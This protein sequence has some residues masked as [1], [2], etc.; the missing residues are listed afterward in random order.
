MHS[1]FVSV[2]MALRT[3]S[4]SDLTVSTTVAYLA[5]RTRL[6]RRLVFR[7]W[8]RWGGW[9]KPRWC[10]PL[11]PRGRRRLEHRDTACGRRADI[12]RLLPKVVVRSILLLRVHAS[13][14][15]A[16]VRATRSV[17][18]TASLSF[19][20]E[21][22]ETVV[23][24]DTLLAEHASQSA[25][26]TRV[27]AANEASKHGG[28]LHGEAHGHLCCLVHGIL[29][30][31]LRLALAVLL[32]VQVAA[33]LMAALTSFCWKPPPLLLL[34]PPPPS[35]DLMAD[36]TA[37]PSP[38]KGCKQMSAYRTKSARAG[39]PLTR[40]RCRSDRP[41]SSQGCC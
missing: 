40:R 20:Y 17:L 37:S 14:A 13:H 9:V 2:R 18:T 32:V 21:M 22:F 34:L 3:I 8:W 24:S 31:A 28:V 30:V 19:R 36:R 10:A 29:L 4:G 15:L 16:L 11:R 1:S 23:A 26:T 39:N 41:S 12:A 38:A 33:W 5:H 7:D 25:E 6:T 27:A 35:T